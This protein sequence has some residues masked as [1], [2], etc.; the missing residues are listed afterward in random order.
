ML[1]AKLDFEVRSDERSFLLR[2][3]VVTRE[4][5]TGER[6]LRIGERGEVAQSASSAQPLWDAVTC[7][8]ARDGRERRGV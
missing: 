5:R 8:A 4:L 2:V 1:L 7:A 6:A 3:G